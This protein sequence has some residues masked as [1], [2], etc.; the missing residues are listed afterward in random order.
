MLCMHLFFMPNIR[1]YISVINFLKITLKYTLLG[2]YFCWVYFK[3]RRPTTSHAWQ[4]FVAQAAIVWKYLK[5]QKVVALP[6]PAY[7]P[8]LTPCDFF[9]FPRLK[10]HLAGR[11]YQ[12]RKNVCSAIFQCLT[13][14]PQKD[15]ENRIWSWIKRL[16]LSL[17]HG[18][19]YFEGLR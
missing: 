6:L 14:L 4:C 12:T 17:S 7:S 10:K 16:K 9:V 11:K 3:N 8:D 1:F 5:H 18:G 2:F 13:N 15:Y 19:D